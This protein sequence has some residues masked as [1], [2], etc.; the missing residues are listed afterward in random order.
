MSKSSN[1]CKE[2]NRT[3]EQQDYSCRC[4]SMQKEQSTYSAHRKM[5]Q[6]PRNMDVKMKQNFLE[7]NKD[8]S[9]LIC[10]VWGTAIKHSPVTKTIKVILSAVPHK[11]LGGLTLY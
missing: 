11:R 5:P 3:T 8:C 9:F 7:E 4:K 2:H 10:I 1:V 6:I